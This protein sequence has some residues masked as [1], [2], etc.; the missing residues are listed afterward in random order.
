MTAKQEKLTER[1]NNFEQELQGSNF[2]M[3]T[4][5]SMIDNKQAKTVD[6]IH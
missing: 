5:I 1:V 2:K 3:K 6:V 4:A